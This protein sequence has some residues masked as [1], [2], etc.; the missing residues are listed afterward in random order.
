[1]VF[2]SVILVWENGESGKSVLQN[3]D[4][5][6]SSAKENVLTLVRLGDGAMEERGRMEESVDLHAA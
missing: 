4:W 3:V 6:N 1:M 5:G 2:L